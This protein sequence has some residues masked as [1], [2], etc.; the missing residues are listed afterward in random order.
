MIFANPTSCLLRSNIIRRKL[1]FSRKLSGI[2]SPKVD[3]LKYYYVHGTGTRSLC[4]MKVDYPG[5][6]VHDVIINGAK[7]PS[8]IE[9]LLSSICGCEQAT[10]MY[11]ARSGISHSP[12]ITNI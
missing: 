2:E 5:G 10:A 11:I 1:L 6:N 7:G 3:D 9:V 12:L 8:A 4:E